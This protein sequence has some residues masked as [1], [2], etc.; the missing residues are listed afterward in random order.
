VSNL[1]IPEDLKN[2]VVEPR[3]L[4]FRP[5]GDC[6]MDGDNKLVCR[7]DATIPAGEAVQIAKLLA[8]GPSS[9]SV[10]SEVAES[11]AKYAAEDESS[12][13]NKEGEDKSNCLICQID[14]YINSI[15]GT[16][17]TQNHE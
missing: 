17:N 16:P 12:L 5:D 6:I 15:I 14:D 2:E 13:H 9:L 8:S 4:P 7:I 1:I 10:L 11:L 3:K